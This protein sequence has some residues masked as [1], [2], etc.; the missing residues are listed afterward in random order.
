M[1]Q[2][3]A[4]IPRPL[5]RTNQWT[6]VLSVVLTWLTGFY[7]LLLIPLL[8]GLGGILFNFNPVMRMAK[9]FLKKPMNA[10]IP[11]DRDDQ[12]FNQLIATF[13]LGGG[14][15]SYAAGW[16]TLAYAFTIMVAVA[17][18]VAI[19]GFCVG[20]FIRYQWKQWQFRRSRKA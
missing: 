18:S 20:C 6:I 17:A 16:M 15:I 9:T 8:A 11:E 5:V 4:V 13:F 14:F 12:R 7:W 19:L 10:Y 2:Q 1:V 3:S